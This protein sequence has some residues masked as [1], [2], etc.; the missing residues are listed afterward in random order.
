MCFASESCWSHASRHG[1]MPYMALYRT[2]F[3]LIGA[4]LCVI[5]NRRAAADCPR[6]CQDALLSS[7]GITD[8]AAMSYDIENLHKDILSF[9]SLILILLILL[10]SLASIRSMSIVA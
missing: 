8:Y 1:I 3:R 6:R 10:S 7:D 2:F 4:T 5:L 9:L